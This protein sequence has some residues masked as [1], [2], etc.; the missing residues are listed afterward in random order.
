[1]FEGQFGGQYTSDS[2]RNVFNTCVKK[3]GIKSKATPHTLRHSFVTHL[4]EQGTDLRYIQTLLGHRS[5]KTTEIYTHI[6]THAL[7]KI[8]SPLDNL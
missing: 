4:L 3:A 5:S 6:T 2:I 1:L 8:R 7:E